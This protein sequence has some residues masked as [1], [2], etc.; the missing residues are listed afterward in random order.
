MIWKKEKAAR[1]P[2]A[3]RV[4]FDRALAGVR[5]ASGAHVEQEAPATVLCFFQR[6][7]FALG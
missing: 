7:Q 3:T 4:L 2:V 1:C 5:S 6:L